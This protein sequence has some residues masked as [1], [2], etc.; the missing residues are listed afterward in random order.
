MVALKAIPVAWRRV[1]A[2]RVV[3]SCQELISPPG[4]EA[5]QLAGREGLRLPDLRHP[6]KPIDIQST[7]WKNM[8]SFK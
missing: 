3:V 8:K 4:T 5:M 6:G 2:W 1:V 7:E